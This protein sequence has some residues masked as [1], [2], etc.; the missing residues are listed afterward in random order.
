LALT[1]SACGGG[2][3]ASDGGNGSLV[4]GKTFTMALPADPGTLDPHMTSVGAAFVLDRFL[5]D[6]LLNVDPSGKEVPALASSWEATTTTAT[7]TLRKGV[8]CSDGSPLTAADVADNI[9]FVG[10]PANSSSRLG[11]YVPQ[12]ATAEADADAGTVTVTSPMDASFLARNVGSLPIVCATGMKDRSK[13]AQ[14]SSGTGEFELTEAVANDHYTLKRRKD[15]AWGPGDWDSDQKGL[16][17]Q[18]VLRVIPNESTAANLLLSGEINLASVSGADK[19]RLQ[20][21]KLLERTSEQPLGQLWFNQKPGTPGQDEAVRRALTQAVD[22][23]KLATVMSGGDGAKPTGLIPKGLSPCNDDTVSGNVAAFDDAAATAALDAA[24]WTDGDGGI[25][26]KD[27]KKLSLT[28]Y[29]PAQYGAPGAAGAELARDAWTKIGADVTIKS[30][31]DA[32]AG[33][34]IVAGQGSW[35]VAIFPVGVDLPSMIVPFV[36][37]PTPPTGTN[38]AFID[39]AD[40]TDHVAAAGKLAGADGCDDWAAAEEALFKK[41]DMVPVYN[42]VQPTYAKG[43]T[44]DFSVGILDPTSIRMVE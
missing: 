23:E 6:S 24:G 18:V 2:S 12:G 8:T 27:G 32:Q 3:D 37:G 39:N 22:L 5:Y 30:M 10:D 1:L 44:F 29:Y 41:N 4:D 14:G 11:V 19:K 35:D 28:L 42:A 17:D 25:R 16:P 26:Q 7:F 13:L 40:Y 34:I 20:A 36:S 21:Q 43:A 38:F 15:Y 9:N 33:E 31:S